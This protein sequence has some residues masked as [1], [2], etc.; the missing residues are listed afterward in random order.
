MNTYNDIP[1]EYREGAL[2]FIRENVQ[3][4]TLTI[5]K[6][7]QTYNV[8]PRTVQRLLVKHKLNRTV[9]EA[10]KLTAKLRNY[11][12]LR[13]PEHLK[14]KRNKLPFGLRYKMLYEHPYCTL[15][16]IKS[17]EIPL[18]IDHI[19]NNPSNNNED[20]LQVLCMLCNQGKKK[21]KTP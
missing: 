18:Q 10:N 14:A 3:N 12:A 13:K 9:A 1:L 2:D 16:H 7:A 21:Y 11:D 15:C 20:N 19:D 6:I 8:T 4:S 17:N 5:E